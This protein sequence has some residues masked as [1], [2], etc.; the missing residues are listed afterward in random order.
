MSPTKNGND[1]YLLKN[2]L[3]SNTLTD[4]T[5]FTENSP[6]KTKPIKLQ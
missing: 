3:K 5:S 4:I 6:E 1:N 2:L